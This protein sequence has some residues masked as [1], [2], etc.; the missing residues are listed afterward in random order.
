MTRF[1]KASFFRVML[2]FLALCCL[3]VPLRARADIGPKPSVHVEFEHM[4]NA[5]CYATLL[6]AVRSTGPSSAWDGTEEGIRLY[7]LD[8]EIWQGCIDD[9]DPGGFYFV[10][11]GWRVDESG[12]FAWTYY[13]PSRFKVLL[14]FPDSGEYLVSG[15]YER[16][17]FDSYYTIDLAGMDGSTLLTAHR[18]YD[19]TWEL[20]SLVCRILLTVLLEMGVALLF[21]FRSK[22]QLKIILTVNAATQILLNLALN[23]INYGQGGMAYVL[24]YVLL[25]LAVVAAEVLLY[26]L[27]LCRAGP[28]KAGKGRTVGYAFAANIFSFVLGMWLSFRIP[29]IF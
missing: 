12:S 3:V 4:G 21:G 23:L 19:Y 29:G 7:R 5:R 14:Y 15:I 22:R 26:T 2:L 17:A 18:S 8:R 24:F 9:E 25:E 1:R 10:Q 16:Y 27:L 13:P 11:E 6:S 28:E 20:I